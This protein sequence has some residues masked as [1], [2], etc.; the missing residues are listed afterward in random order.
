MGDEDVGQA[1]VVLKLL[2]QV[3]HLRLHRHVERGHR[4]V[5]DDDLRLQRESPG[6]ADALP[7]AARELV[8][9]A[10]DEVGVQ[11]DP[12]QQVARPGGS[13]LGRHD[14]GVDLPG[15]RDDVADGHPRVQRGVRVLEDDLDVAAQP[16][17][18]LA[19]EVGDV[20][21]LVEHPAARRLLQGQQQLGDRRLAA[22]GLPDQ[23]ERLAGV[24][25]KV[26]PVHRAHV[27]HGLL[28]Q[29]ALGDREV[30]GQPL[31]PEQRLPAAHDVGPVWTVHLRHPAPLPRSGRRC[32]DP[33]P[34][35][36]AGAAPR[37]SD[38][39]SGSSA[40]RRGSRVAGAPGR[41]AT[42]RSG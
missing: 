11:P 17:Q 22:A 25:R 6:D 38:R 21:A 18:V 3:D 31:D 7:L 12:L 27:A 14:V 37:R 10:V 28:E 1:E 40:A 24:E 13:L 34:P 39:W 32:A 9:V 8:R 15:L 42:R 41:G 19:L 33:R 35:R 29:H 23:T 26:H 5:T 16:P 30:L 2:E 36:A 4:L 20:V